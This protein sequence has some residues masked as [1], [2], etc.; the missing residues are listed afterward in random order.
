MNIEN[1]HT[2]R[3]TAYIFGLLILSLHTFS[4]NTRRLIYTEQS[5]QCFSCKKHLSSEE[6]QTHHIVPRS[7]GGTNKRRNGIGLCFKCHAYFDTLAVGEKRII[8]TN[9]GL[10][11]LST[12]PISDAS[13]NL[14]RVGSNPYI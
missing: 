12:I 3:H 13:D 14:F 10:E 9:L 6:M 5:G 4:L 11:T 8:D 2:L 1:L 7:M